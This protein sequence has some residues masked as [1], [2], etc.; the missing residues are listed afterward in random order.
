M[1]HAEIVGLVFQG[2]S[3]IC[4]LLRHHRADVSKPPSHTASRAEWPTEAA[5]HPVAALL[6]LVP[7]LATPPLFAKLGHD[8]MGEDIA[9]LSNQR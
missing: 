7:V 6:S 9:N 3:R 4:Q 1:F 5:V 8:R 2:E